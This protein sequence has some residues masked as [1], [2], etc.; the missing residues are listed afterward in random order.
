MYMVLPMLNVS[1]YSKFRASQSSSAPGGQCRGDRNE[2]KVGL[3]GSD[4]GKFLM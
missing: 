3:P 4:A 1:E 2:R